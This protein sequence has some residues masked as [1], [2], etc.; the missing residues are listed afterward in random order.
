MM[1]A[2]PD[3][4]ATDTLP[5][6]NI[7]QAINDLTIDELRRLGAWESLEEISKGTEFGAVDAF[8]DSIIIN[9][10][11]FDAAAE[12]YVTLNYDEETALGESF[13]ANVSGRLEEGEVRIER[14]DVDVSDLFE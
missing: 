12:V 7:F 1:H 10:D 5:F 2:E 13:L 6:D 11:K 8:Y 4:A 3:Q 14:F 9:G